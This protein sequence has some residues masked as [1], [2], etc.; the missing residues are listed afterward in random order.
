M[1]EN[2]ICPVYVF[3]PFTNEFG[4]GLVDYGGS[5]GKSS[6][7]FSQLAAALMA[8]KQFNERDPYI[9]PQLS[10]LMDCDIQLNISKGFAFDSVPETH[11][12]S[13]TLAVLPDP[14]AIAGPSSDLVGLELGNMA[15]AAQYPIVYARIFNLRSAFTE[16]SNFS[17][18]VFPDVGSTAVAVVNFIR[19]KGRFNYIAVLYESTDTSIQR[20]EALAVDFDAYKMAWA[21]FGYVSERSNGGTTSA[22]NSTLFNVV[23]KIKDSGYRTIIIAMDHPWT[24]VLEVADAVEALG[25]NN[26]DYFYVWMDWLSNTTSWTINSNMT[27]LM[28]GSAFITPYP[29]YSLRSLTTSQNYIPFE[30]SWRQQGKDMVDK[31]NEVNPILPGE[32]GYVYAEDD[33]FLEVDPDLYASF[34]YDAVMSIG[35][36]ACKAAAKETSDTISGLDHRLSILNL[37]FVGATGTLEFGYK[38]TERT[39]RLISTTTFAALN[40]WNGSYTLTDVSYPNSGTT[41]VKLTPFTYADGTNNPPEL[42]RDEPEQNYIGRAYRA[43]GLSFMTFG[44]LLALASMVWLVRFRKEPTVSSSQPIFLHILCVGAVVMNASIYVLAWDEGA[45]WSKQKLDHACEAFP[46][47]LYTGQLII[48]GSLFFKL[49]FQLLGRVKPTK[50]LLAIMIAAV[51]CAYA[52]L[53]VWTIQD[54]N[55]WVRTVIDQTSGESIGDC[56]GDLLIAYSVILFVICFIPV[57]LTGWMAWKATKIPEAKSYWTFIMIMCHLEALILATPIAAIL[58]Q[59]T[60][61][62]QEF[63]GFAILIWFFATIA[64]V[65]SMIPPTIAYYRRGSNDSKRKRGEFGNGAVTGMAEPVIET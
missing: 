26:G 63:V 23:Q 28:D 27:K 16:Y 31:L 25:M 37:S 8:E 53:F 7:G 2:N 24:S 47:F 34:M 46:W 64:V 4:T 10:W 1:I 30:A 9:V 33:F 59:Q 50:I 44:I 40:I 61:P 48:Y 19:V 15:Q 39:S 35:L 51:I 57:V 12:A 18:S 45:G 41:W 36:G 5:P 65:I 3:A 43:V 20:Q 29:D 14:C 56:D 22:R 32:P 54:P 49:W 13:Q 55:E 11:L 52:T 6:P 62:E 17:A 60:K 38:E 58:R 42:L 21:S